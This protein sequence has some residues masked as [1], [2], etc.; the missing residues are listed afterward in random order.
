MGKKE[1]RINGEWFIDKD[2]EY[3]WVL[4]RI[5]KH[6][7]STKTRFQ[8]VE[9]I[10]TYNFGRVVVLDNKIQSAEKD[11]F[12][13]HEALVH[14]SM[15]THPHPKKILIL[16]GG[17]GATL[18]EVLK[19]PSVKKVVMVDIDEEFVSLCKNNLEKWHGGS[20]DDER[21]EL[22]FTDAKEYVKETKSQFDVIIADISD[23]VEGGPS[24][25]IYT[26]EFYS[27]IKRALEPDGIFV[28][29]ATEAHYIPVKSIYAD[30]FR[31]ISEIFPVS[32]FYDEFIPSFSC[33]WGFAT[34][35]LKYSPRELS[36][37]MVDERL[38]ER[39]LGELSY[40][41]QETH[42]RLFHIPKCLRKL[43][44]EK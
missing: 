1:L 30:I 42:E 37:A 16:G 10:D 5:K 2:T 17:E 11:E 40:Y 25:M 24:Q 12:I 20:F 39:G 36:S 41:D 3:K 28:T 13:Y 7:L 8:C 32:V 29:H 33:L 44:G 31:I 19:H 18:R 6:L 43:L 9:F 14:P 4:H 38:K 35:S 23:P 26:K 27:Y 21:V 15:I 34:A 22:L